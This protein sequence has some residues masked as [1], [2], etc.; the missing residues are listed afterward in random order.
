[1]SFSFDPDAKYRYMGIFRQDKTVLDVSEVSDRIK[2]TL[3]QEAAADLAGFLNKKGQRFLFCFDEFD[4]NGTYRME[5]SFS[6]GQAVGDG[7]NIL[8][9]GG[10]STEY[11]P[12]KAPF[13]LMRLLY[14]E[15][16]SSAE[17]YVQCKKEARWERVES[18]LLPGKNQTD[19][20]KIRPP[21]LQLQYDSRYSLPAAEESGYTSAVLSIHAV[22]KNRLDSLGIPYAVGTD[23]EDSARIFIRI[24]RAEGLY[25][26]ELEN[27]GENMARD[28]SLGSR[29]ARRRTSFYATSFSVQETG[30]GAWQLLMSPDGNDLD[31]VE[32]TLQTLLEQGEEEI[33]L[34]DLYRPLAAGNVQEAIRS[35]EENGTIAFTRWTFSEYQAMDAK[36]LALG[37]FLMTC[38]GQNPENSY[39]LAASQ[40]QE[41]DGRIRF[42][43]EGLP[44]RIDRDPGDKWAQEQDLPWKS[45]KL[46][47]RRKDR[48]LRVT[49]YEYPL[50]RP[51][52]CLE[53][54]RRLFDGAEDA[55]VKLNELSISC[56]EKA[57][58]TPGVVN[59]EE[60]YLVF[61]QD[62][63]AGSMIL[64]HGI[65]SGFSKEDPAQ[66][67]R[68]ESLKSIYYHAFDDSDCWRNMLTEEA[69]EKKEEIFFIPD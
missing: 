21:F 24:P 44:D 41:E 42:F 28:W 51:G 6:R 45:S 65:I 54:C 5:H 31:T 67:G 59:T 1:M 23:P 58:D 61:S 62:F 64:D 30:E 19:E 22:I 46:S 18:A 13:A 47:Y 9:P 63:E 34:Y 4:E 43:Y 35:L 25:L 16:P 14:R 27:M 49:L 2:L 50:D 57:A 11:Q 69:R 66:T 68:A 3:R 60:V 12:M 17:F 39:R 38:F 29:N 26:E 10:N 33:F 32:E 55:G 20:D 48:S 15:A 7:K 8:F 37:R 52:E 56:Y 53:I 40:T 36:T